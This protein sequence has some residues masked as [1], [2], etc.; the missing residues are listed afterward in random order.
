MIDIILNYNVVGIIIL[1]VFAHNLKIPKKFVIAMCFGCLTMF[2]AGG[3][4]ILRQ[5]DCPKS[6]ILLHNFIFELNILL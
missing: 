3:V 1:N 2:I 5:T 6:K 4:E